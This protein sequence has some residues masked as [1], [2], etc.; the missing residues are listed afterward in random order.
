[1]AL[2]DVV[3]GHSGSGLGLD[4]VILEVF[5][6][7]SDSM[8]PCFHSRF[9]SLLQHNQS[10]LSSPSVG[11]CWVLSRISETLC[12]NF[13]PQTRITAA[14]CR[15]VQ[16]S[17]RSRQLFWSLFPIARLI[18]LFCNSFPKD[19]NP[20]PVPNQ[21]IPAFYLSLAWDGS[22][23][24]AAAGAACS[25]CNTKQSQHLH[26]E[27]HW[28]CSLRAAE[29]GEDEQVI[30]SSWSSSPAMLSTELHAVL[31]LMCHCCSCTALSVH[32]IIYFREAH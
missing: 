1:M 25:W 5:P 15:A 26:Q 7:L 8:I 21:N 27:L 4:L 32:L 29:V 19:A 24:S 6:N 28:G 9:I 30:G 16:A 22:Q 12:R 23:S 17:L 18:S 3:S 31:Q 13:W 11:Q 14:V 20:V 10:G 2:R